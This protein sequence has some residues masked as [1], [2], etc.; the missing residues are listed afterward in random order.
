MRLKMKM[1]CIFTEALEIKTMQSCLCREV[2]TGSM[3]GLLLKI[4]NKQILG[5]ECFLVGHKKG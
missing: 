4:T 2:N 5:S 3:L 1:V